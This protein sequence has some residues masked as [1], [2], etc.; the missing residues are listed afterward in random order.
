MRCRSQVEKL[1]NQSAKPTGCRSSS[2]ATCPNSRRVGEQHVAQLLVG[3]VALVG[4]AFE[5]GQLVHHRDDGR[6]V[7][8]TYRP[9]DAV[10]AHACLVSQKILEISS[11]LP[12]SCSA[13]AGSTEPLAPE[14]PASLVASLK[15]WCRFGYFSKCGALK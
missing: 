9:Y 4:R 14:A 2:T 15:S 6:H 13:T 5:V 10:R 7:L 1:R 3:E 11:I 8:G 12:S